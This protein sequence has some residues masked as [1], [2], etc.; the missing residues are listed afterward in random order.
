MVE[1]YG[2]RPSRDHGLQIAEE[3][4][5]QVPVL[6]VF[7]LVERDGF[8]LATQA[9]V[10]RGTQEARIDDGK[11]GGQNHQPVMESIAGSASQPNARGDNNYRKP[12]EAPVDTENRGS[13]AWSSVHER[14]AFEV[15]LLCHFSEMWSLHNLQIGYQERMNDWTKIMLYKECGEVWKTRQHQAGMRSRPYFVMRK[16]MIAGSKRTHG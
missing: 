14:T 16:S 1:E 12:S 3:L 2:N 6:R 15:H 4:R 8:I 7:K 10:H 5:H 9:P 13:D 11:D